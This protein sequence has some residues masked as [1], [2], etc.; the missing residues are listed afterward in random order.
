MLEPSGFQNI[1]KYSCDPLYPT[2]SIYTSVVLFV[3]I[4]AKRIIS[5]R[6]RRHDRHLA[7]RDAFLPMPTKSFKS[8]CNNMNEVWLKVVGWSEQNPNLI[9][10]EEN[11]SDGWLI[12]FVFFLLI[13]LLGKPSK[14]HQHQNNSNNGNLK[15]YW[16]SNRIFLFKNAHS[17]QGIIV[18]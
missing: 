16:E 5:R 10:E 7:E 8:N 15:S 9:Q 17:P 14:S 12:K 4:Y 11:G 1:M 18:G 2:A 6:R 13:S 3:T